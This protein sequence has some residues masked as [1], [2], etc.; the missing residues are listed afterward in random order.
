M[1]ELK[2]LLKDYKPIELASVFSGLLLDPK[3]QF[4]IYRLEDAVSL[5]LSY[6]KGEKDPNPKI[7][8]TIFNTLGN[9][10]G[11]NEDPPEDVFV[12]KLWLGSQSYKVLL[13]L[14][15]GSIYQT[16][17]L[18]DILEDMP[19]EGMFI[20]LYETIQEILEISDA[21]VSKNN[22]TTYKIGNSDIVEDFSYDIKN[23]DT[24][25]NSACLLC[26]ENLNLDL[27]IVDYEKLDEQEYGNKNIE[28]NPFYIKDKMLI[29]L[30][31]TAITLCI[32]RHIIDFF[33]LN[34]SK[35]ILISKFAQYQAKKIHDLKI[36]NQFEGCPVKFSKIK[37]I[38]DY[39]YSEVILRLDEGYYYHFI[40]LLDALVG[41]ENNW[42][43]GFINSEKI[44]EL[45]SEQINNSKSN[46]LEKNEYNKGCSIVV[47]CGIGRFS[48]MGIDFI[49]DDIWKVEAI[50]IHDLE[51]ISNDTDCSPS[52]IWRIIDT[53]YKLESI[54]TKLFNINGFINLYGY[55]KNNNYSF[56]TQSE[57][58]TSQQITLLNLA[59]NFQ[60]SLREQVLLSKDLREA[61]HPILGNMI[62]HRAYGISYF[63]TDDRNN[64]YMIKNAD[65]TIFRIAYIDDENTIWLE[66]S[67]K[68]DIDISLQYQ[69][70]D[71]VSTWFGK[72][73][74]ILE[75]YHISLNE[76]FKIWNLDFSFIPN[77]S[78]TKYDITS[79]DVLSSFINSYEDKVL[80][81][82]FDEALV[83]GFRLEKNYSEKAIVLSFLSFLLKHGCTFDIDILLNEIVINDSAK[84]TH[85]FTATKYSEYFLSEKTKP[86]YIQTIDEENIKLN[87][88]WECQE[89]NNGNIIVG[90]EP[91]IKY[92]Q[93]IVSYIW[94]KLQINLKALDRE[95]LIT[96]L[97]KNIE[98]SILEHN[99]WKRTFKAV[100]SIHTTSETLYVKT[101]Q[102]LGQ[103]N[104]ATIS[105]R[106]VIEMAICESSVNCGKNPGLID[107]QE[108]TCLASFMHH[109]GGLSD[110]ILYDAI[111]S[112][113]IISSFGDILFDQSFH[114]MIISS[115]GKNLHKNELNIARKNYHENFKE[116]K[117]VSEVNHL[118]D[119]NFLD[120]FVTEFG[121]SID[122]AR[123]FIDFIEDYG[124]K[125]NKLVFS[126][127]YN[128]LIEIFP[129]EQL[130]IYTVILDSFIIHP[131]KEW[132]KIPKP[133]KSNDWQPWKF[134]RRYSVAM[135]PIIQIDTFERLLTISPQLVRD[136]F[137]N[138]LRN[139]NESGLDEAHFQS[140]L[141]RQWIGTKRS[142][143]GLEFNTL[144]LEQIIKLGLE[145]KLELK[146][147]EIL[148][149]K[150]DD[151]GDVDVFA[152]DKS[153]NIVYVIE[154]KSL[155]FAK[156]QGEIAK[157]LYDFKGKETEQG[158]KDRL[159]K[160]IMRLEELKKDIT[161]IT[162]YTKLYG[163]IKI[164]GMV[165]FSQL[166]PMIF[167]KNRSFQ[168]EIKFLSLDELEK[169]L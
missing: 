45:I 127:T 100:C 112:E 55:V 88:G 114:E 128:E 91:C 64:F 145:A 46:L 93:C 133:Y 51:T 144:V 68:K 27:P 157:Q 90:K 137:I 89:R 140:K 9:L 87:L 107:I 50:N 28:I 122:D 124:F 67:I 21:L 118:F 3:Y 41:L 105:S 95:A 8:Q 117:S 14:W 53:S 164:I 136:S 17:I 58:E 47:A 1:D 141:M 119:S 24:H 155:Q 71:T 57:E 134:R 39:L 80:T 92:L 75:Q 138:L 72:I 139:C 11:H 48:T 161:G 23:L 83:K 166:V 44:T 13:G 26:D 167:D 25:K 52:L 70:F 86:I 32:K 60:I 130:D 98:V 81:T 40:F 160:H 111:P 15:E 143:S 115:Y 37:N 131:R 31:P 162:K 165:V 153:K 74:K 147:S 10:V 123:K 34:F 65:K 61:E 20:K 62:M 154:C 163:D 2:T 152:W 108:L 30:L 148:N 5:C 126:L 142:K 121:Y 79:K 18:L 54:G 104:A 125:Q 19:K 84:N 56:M 33:L 159:L 78:T 103:F 4:H 82:T 146:L 102:K 99:R 106:L 132:T 76:D 59:T 129:K 43:A 69:T 158:K 94:K 135:K 96:K 120:A 110:A 12:S 116:Q 66:Q 85:F 149:K 97:L 169:Y 16:Q 109:I 49:P 113:L 150:M 6:A 35:D 36:F 38:D 22:L 77:I 42:F 7:V 63:E 168:E 151:L 156:T 101:S 73:M 29:C